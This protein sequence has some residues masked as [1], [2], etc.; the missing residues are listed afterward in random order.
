[1]HHPI[2]WLVIKAF[3]SILHLMSIIILLAL[4]P[5][6]LSSDSLI[7]AWHFLLKEYKKVAKEVSTH[8]H[9]HCMQPVYSKKVGKDTIHRKDWA[10]SLSIAQ[11]KS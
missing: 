9:I 1:M 2:F 8:P 5:E 4:L 7:S 3:H 6:K 10:H 11:K